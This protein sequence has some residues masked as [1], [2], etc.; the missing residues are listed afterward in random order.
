MNRSR[1]S[2]RWILVLGALAL[3]ALALA[4]WYP[5]EAPQPPALEATGEDLSGLPPVQP[6]P[7]A[8]PEPQSWTEELAQERFSPSDKAEAGEDLK[9]PTDP[10]AQEALEVQETP[11]TQPIQPVP[12]AQEPDPVAFGM[13]DVEQLARD[14]ASQPYRDSQGQVPEFLLRLS[15]AQWNRIRFRPETGLWHRQ[16]L[17]FEIHFFHPG[18]VYDRLVKIHVIDG[19]AVQ[20][21]PFSPGQFLYLD[22]DLA[23]RVEGARLGY[24][25]FQILASSAPGEAKVPV[26]LFL[27]A[28][29]FR[30]AGSSSIFGL[31]ARGLALDTGLPQGEEFPYF[32]E[33]WIEKPA[34]SA[35]SLTVYA[36]L[37]S[38]SATGAYRFVIAPGPRVTIDADCSVYFRRAPEK[39]GLAPLTSMFFYGEAS[40]G[41]PGD[42]RPEVHN[43]DGLLLQ[44]REGGWSWRP[45][46]NP[47]RL[48][49]SSFAME[50]PLGFGLLQRDSD[51]D[52][53]QDLEENYQQRPSL[54]IQP[55][56]SWGAGRVELVEIPSDREIYDNLVAFWV[57]A[58]AQ[59]GQGTGSPDK[60]SLSYRMLWLPSGQLP[61]EH[62]LGQVTATRKVDLGGG[63]TRFILDFEG[64]PLDQLE[65]DA[66]LASQVEVT[67]EAKI[68]EKDLQK[69]HVTGG[70]RLSFLMSLPQSDRL[71]T[72]I[73]TRDPWAGLRITAVLKKGDNLPDALTELWVWDQGI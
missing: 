20:S 52:H 8:G 40:N 65:A 54:W 59:D 15:E 1:L 38:P 35:P 4:L 50:D 26:A 49:I 51:F 60:L 42:F 68:L 62:Q 6:E 12:T 5:R 53:Y 41:R 30:A 58:K 32:R 33:F 3:G 2:H 39:L 44:D 55:K 11:P 7:I 29:Y 34:A 16:D 24:A 66:G 45:L 28:S 21:W 70:W 22:E 73:P 69:N 36:L 17:P 25:G 23:A 72:L 10:E 19:G 47:N 67:G 64:G 37:D 56:G 63:V 18:L 43:S 57:P 31:S 71:S 13:A 27:G 46:T 14:L 48:K 61:Q 9:A